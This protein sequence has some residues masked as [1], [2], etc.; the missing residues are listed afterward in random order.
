[1][2]QG[3]VLAEWWQ[4]LLARIIDM[5]VI[6]VVAAPF[7]SYNLRTTEA[8]GGSV[9]FNGSRF[10]ALMLITILYYA[11]MHGFL[12]KTLGKMALGLKVVKKGTTDQIALPNAFGRVIIEQ[13]L[14][15]TCI[16]GLLDNFFPLWD[17]DRQAIHDKVAGS[18]V[19][20]AK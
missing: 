6:G 10:F 15:L 4:R 12:G 16:G 3:P 11:L 9:S 14:W 1:M 19:I 7:G 2:T 18:Q 13:V 8:A 17:K 5:I 20:K